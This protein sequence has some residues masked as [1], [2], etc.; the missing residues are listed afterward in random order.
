[1]TDTRRSFTRE[2]EETRRESLIVAALEL[3][4]EGGPKAATVR[5]IADRAGITP[6]LI[7]HYFQTKEQL[8]REAYA[9]V[10]ER[11]TNHAKTAAENGGAGPVDALS[12][13]IRCTLRAPVMTGDQVRLWAGFIHMVHKD[14]EMREI[15]KDSYLH[16]R[17]ILEFWIAQLPS[18]PDPSETRRLAIACNAILDGLWLEGGALPDAFAPDEIMEIGLRSISTILNVDLT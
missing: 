12:A 18:C 16:F 13:L 14:A 11:M 3:M 10:M 7:R 15:H 9:W 17:G 1:M 8:T 2:S 5:A 6:G 4:A